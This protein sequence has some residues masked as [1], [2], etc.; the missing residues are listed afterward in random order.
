MPLKRAQLAIFEASAKIFRT[1]R[2]TPTCLTAMRVRTFGRIEK[3]KM[4]SGDSAPLC[5]VHR[6]GSFAAGGGRR[7]LGGMSR[8]SG[9]ARSDAS[10][11]SAASVGF[12]SGPLAGL[13]PVLCDQPLV[14]IGEHVGRHRVEETAEADAVQE[15]PPLLTPRADESIHRQRR[16]LALQPNVLALEPARCGF[17]FFEPRQLARNL[18]GRSGPTS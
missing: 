2:K 16:D 18:A 7:K 8:S 17:Q 12:R 14:Q 11:A 4:G 13:A 15:A 5:S 1:D 3:Q 6:T 10:W 9:V